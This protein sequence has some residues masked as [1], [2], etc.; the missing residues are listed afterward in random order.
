M[1]PYKRN[2]KPPVLVRVQRLIEKY[3]KKIALV[4]ARGYLQQY[5]HNQDILDVIADLEYQNGNIVEAGRYWYFSKEH[6]PIIRKAIYSFEKRYGF[7]KPLILRK[8]I[9]HHFKSP[10]N[11]NISTKIGLYEMIKSIENEEGEVPSYCKTYYEHFKVAL[12]KK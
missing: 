3:D 10:A 6:N 4:H 11:F 2:H 12:N 1:F 5:Y 9:F 8:L 7:S